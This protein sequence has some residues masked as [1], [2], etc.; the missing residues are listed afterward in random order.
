MLDDI[1]NVQQRIKYETMLNKLS[2]ATVLLTA[3][4]FSNGSRK[5]RLCSCIEQDQLLDH[6]GELPALK[7]IANKMDDDDGIYNSSMR[8]KRLLDIVN[9]YMEH[10][11]PYMPC[12]FTID[13]FERPHRALSTTT[14]EFPPPPPFPPLPTLAPLATDHMSVR[15]GENCPQNMHP[16]TSEMCFDWAKDS[17]FTKSTDNVVTI[18]TEDGEMHQSRPKSGT[19]GFTTTITSQVNGS[20]CFVF[21]GDA[22]L[23]FHDIT[24]VILYL[25]PSAALGVVAYCPDMA[26]FC[27]CAPGNLI[28]PSPPWHMAVSPP[29]LPPTLPLPPFPPGTNTTHPNASTW[30]PMVPAGQIHAPPSPPYGPPRPHYGSTVLRLAPR[31]SVTDGPTTCATAA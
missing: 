29:P 25:P 18:N 10:S 3:L 24:T 7:T 30:P 23:G 6:I 17:G 21:R 12:M 8:A 2:W 28:P 4:G 27:V 5:H 16:P 13:C 22:A 26:V 11:N 14:T 15:P 1:E 31:S 19:Y 20:G 9:V